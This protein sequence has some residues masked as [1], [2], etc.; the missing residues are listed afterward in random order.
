MAGIVSLGIGL[1]SREPSWISLLDSEGI[2]LKLCEKTIDKKLQ[3][4]ILPQNQYFSKIQMAKELLKQGLTIISEVCPSKIASFFEEREVNCS[5]TNDNFAL[6]KNGAGSILKIKIGRIFNGR[7][8]WLPFRLKKLWANSVVGFNEIVFDEKKMHLVWHRHS[9]VV[10]KNIRKVI[11]HLI[12]AALHEAGLPYVHKWYWPN[13]K[14]SAFCFRGDLEGQCNKES[15]NNFKSII[16]D[17]GSSMTLSCTASEHMLN[18]GVFEY[19]AKTGAEIANHTCT[20]YVFSNR[21]DNERD[22]YLS[23][24]ILDRFFGKISGFIGPAHFWHS[25]MYKIIEENGYEY[26]SSFGLDHDNM[27]YNPVISGE[28]SNLVE[29]PFHCIGD[30]LPNFNL[31]LSSEVVKKYYFKFLKY[32][33][34]KAE[35]LWIYGHPDMKDRIGDHPDLIR[36]VFEKCSEFPNVWFAQLKTVADWW[37]VRNAE[38]G[39]IC[40]DTLTSRLL[41]NGIPYSPCPYDLHYNVVLPGSDGTLI[42]KAQI[43]DLGFGEPF[44]PVDCYM[45]KGEF[46]LNVG[47]KLEVRSK[48][49]LKM[50]IRRSLVDLKRFKKK[51]ASLKKYEMMVKGGFTYDSEKEIVSGKKLF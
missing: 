30:F 35:P 29:I 2:P 11:A 13:G 43:S 40:F 17:Y 24:K 10:K 48:R 6:A 37:G 32:R 22:F 45:P 41:Y 38:K 28:L 1:L 18:Q 46:S 42:P 9:K 7:Y 15:L 3:I 14:Q 5:I 12:K 16:D 26:A 21:R 27:P 44:Q 49:N 25:S 36:F 20:H 4:F 31:P 51:K 34:D 47:D 23:E 8:V 39:D 33:Y 50:L 19:L